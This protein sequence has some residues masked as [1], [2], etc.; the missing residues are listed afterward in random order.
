M[1]KGIMMGLF[2]AVILLVSTGGLVQA[3]IYTIEPSDDAGIYD[4]YDLTGGTATWFKV[5]WEKWKQT[6][7]FGY[8]K[9][10]LSSI[11]DGWIISSATLHML[12]GSLSDGTPVDLGV[13]GVSDD[14]WDEET[15]TGINEPPMDASY[16]EKKLISQ[17]GWYSWDVTSLVESN[18]NAEDD[19]LS[20]GLKQATIDE[21]SDANRLVSFYSKENPDTAK[22]PYLEVS[23]IPTSLNLLING[24]FEQG[25]RSWNGIAY[26]WLSWGAD[27][28]T[29]CS[30]PYEGVN[31]QEIERTSSESGT[32]EFYQTGIPVNAG[33][34]YKI[35]LWM[36]GN[37]SNEV[38]VKVRKNTSP[39]TTYF[40]R[41]FNI[42]SKWAPYEFTAISN[43]S[44]E[45]ARFLIT[46][47]TDSGK[48]CVDKVSMFNLSKPTILGTVYL[49]SEGG[50]DANDGLTEATAWR[51]LDKL[52]EYD[53][54]PG[55]TVLF[56]RGG[57]WH[58]SITN[59][60]G[61]PDRLVTF[62]AYGEGAKPIINGARVITGW[63]AYD[64]NIYVASG[65]GEKITQLFLNGERQTLARYPNRGYLT[66]DADSP[67]NQV[68]DYD[69]TQPDD[70][71]NGADIYMR[72]W[73]WR[74]E[75]KKV[76]DYIKNDGLITL[77][78]ETASS[79]REGW[80]Y[81]LENKFEELDSPGE[82][83][84]DESTDKLYFWPPAGTDLNTEK[85]EVSTIASCF[86]SERSIEY[87]RIEDLDIRNFSQYGI[88]FS[89]VAKPS[90]IEIVNNDI[91][92][93][94]LQGIRLCNGS[95]ISVENNKVWNIYQ[96]YGQDGA[97]VLRS[98]YLSK[99]IGNEVFNCANEGIWYWNGSEGIIQ[100]NLV[101]DI[102]YIGIRI[103]G[104]EDSP[105]SNNL[106]T[107]N[108]VKRT[109]L[110]LD[111]G[112]GIYGQFI[113]R[114]TISNNIVED[115]IGNADGRP[116]DDTIASE[117]VGIYLD[118]RSRDVTVT[119]N[120]VRNA[121]WGIFLH[122]AS[123]NT[124]R[125]NLVY[126]ARKAALRISSGDISGNIVENN[127]FYTAPFADAA[128]SE[129]ASSLGNIDEYA[130][131]EY[132]YYAQP[133][134]NYA[135]KRKYVADGWVTELLHLSEWQAYSGEDIYSESLDNFFT[136][137]PYETVYRGVDFIEN[138]KF[139]SP[140][141]AGWTPWP[142]TTEISIDENSPLDGNALK[143]YSNDNSQS[144]VGLVYYR[145]PVE[146]DKYYRI[147]FSVYS[148][149]EDTL[150]VSLRSNVSP[151]TYL[152]ETETVDMKP[153]RQEYALILKA[154]DNEPDAR[155]EFKFNSLDTT[156][157]LD[158]ITLYEVET[159]ANNLADYSSIFINYDRVSNEEVILDQKYDDLYGND[160]GSS[161]TLEPLSGQILIKQ[162]TALPVGRW[163]FE[164]GEGLVAR[165]NSPNSNHGTL[166]NMDPSSSWVEG[167]IGKGLAF[168][169]VDDYIKVEEGSGL[170][171]TGPLTVEVWF[172]PEDINSWQ[173]LVANDQWKV[174][175]YAVRIGNKR[176]YFIY[177]IA[178]AQQSVITPPD[179]ITETGR[180]YHVV[181]VLDGTR[182]HIYLNGVE[183][184][185]EPGQT[186]ESSAY[187]VVIGAGT[188]SG[189]FYQ[190]K[191]VIDEVRIYNRAL[192]A[193]EVYEHYLAA[194][195]RGKWRFEEGEGSTAQD[196][197][198]YHNHATLKNMD[199]S[200]SW[201]EGRIGKGLAFDGVDDYVKVEEGSGLD[202]TGPLTVEVWFKPEDIISR[203]S[204]VANDQWK[205]GGYAIR[206]EDK[207]AY[208]IYD[209]AGLQRSV[210]TP[211][212]SITET[213]RWYHVVGVLDG[214]RE[215]IYL[216]GVEV[217]NE[218]GQTPESSAYNV[219]I[220]AGTP[221]GG[222]H[223]F[224]G[225]I[226]EV[227]IYKRALSADEV[228][229]HYRSG[230][231][232]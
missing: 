224:K 118:D 83:Y 175:G 134:N 66:I 157:W 145:F 216:N 12:S 144:D 3:D 17:A 136:F 221:S 148:Y 120:T 183:V 206:I 60:F 34:E 43:G 147:S 142:S 149:K 196:S 6:Q 173:S 11:P 102:G 228:Y 92:N 26:S 204:L 128:V 31:A 47:T 8:L 35:R 22:H 81:Y 41:S 141:T 93:I 185:N 87:V 76:I 96:G 20:L 59:F 58:G 165:D 203:Q 53:I 63:T 212:D 140:T 200:S 122:D 166:K 225:V 42:T 137:E 153:E 36:K 139:D 88:V 217:N 150:K 121:S 79:N 161:I 143:V 104:Y 46:F 184:N 138:G 155:L 90:N 7:M 167:R 57:E 181:G 18:N 193:D 23:V 95:E 188:P 223:Q 44:D 40:S 109:C 13:Y 2:F 29:N 103:G 218:P 168:D 179:S 190:F 131:Y 126:S 226:D 112:G 162:K 37:L 98:P 54:G 5:G 177:N 229:E 48:L 192:S 195:T 129:H 74:I 82:W 52:N 159:Y 208:F 28:Y 97:I 45:D 230:A 176:A 55:A 158:N 113:H 62:G 16:S 130:D 89:D 207:K 110:T 38:V 187:N 169:G 123:N 189:G 32:V 71:W 24:D 9:F 1:K 202:I 108:I 222:F 65:V 163:H 39:Y 67:A 73:A 151:Y 219:V 25:F 107:G 164:E 199:P 180:W 91:S 152:S 85:V 178:G 215:H 174:G 14:N 171:I 213:G 119:D 209:I 100:D 33:D 72:T 201:V 106:I 75:K 117:A 156:F 210:I 10:S 232:E 61:A 146:K 77:D 68:V 211:P 114:D 154:S 125:G 4:G 84:Y 186:P 105:D 19:V 21:P 133:L 80:G 197:S 64:S 205:V 86:S 132:N 78:S 127:T 27:I 170:D 101:Y 111:D 15:L 135:F 231:S 227:R 198:G 115:V 214:T 99:I 30:T 194:D 50:D 116:E 191:G 49:D 69:L 182:E 172:K 70:Y 160:V 94:G 220:G 51:T 56:K 124:V